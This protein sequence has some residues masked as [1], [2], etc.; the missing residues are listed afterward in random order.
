MCFSVDTAPGMVMI[1]FNKI[2]MEMK[3]IQLSVDN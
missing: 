3:E 1:I 2:N